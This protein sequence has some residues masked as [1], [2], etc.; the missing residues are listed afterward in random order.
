[1]TWQNAS[2]LLYFWA[3]AETLST[4]ESVFIENAISVYPNPSSEYI[5]INSKS[6]IKRIEI[7]SLSGQ[8]ILSTKRATQI[9]V[10]HLQAGMYLL[11]VQTV[12]GKLIKKI[13]VE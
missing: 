3:T 13:V 8:L 2:R 1:M 7:Y 6:D 11:N 5:N 12:T 4:S 9:K 10:G